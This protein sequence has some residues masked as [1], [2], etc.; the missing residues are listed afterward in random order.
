LILFF[1]EAAEL[2]ALGKLKKKQFCEDF[3]LLLF[4]NQS[5][6][7]KIRKKRKKNKKI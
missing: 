4:K 7:E 5:K 2:L 1:L 3:E 6:H